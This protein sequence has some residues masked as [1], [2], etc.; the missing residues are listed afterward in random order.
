MCAQLVIDEQLSAVRR[1]GE[2]QWLGRP[3]TVDQFYKDAP[4]RSKPPSYVQLAY[5]R[6]MG[7]RACARV[8]GRSGAQAYHTAA[9]PCVVCRLD[10]PLLCLRKATLTEMALC[11]VCIRRAD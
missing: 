1:A 7:V 3:P 10:C 6:S 11:G 4:W 8:G 5:K 2:G 9:C